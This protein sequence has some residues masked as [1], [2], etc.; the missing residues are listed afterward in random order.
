[1]RV[2]VVEDETLLAEQVKNHLTQQQFSVDLSYDGT[3]GFFK[4]S[5]YPY[6]LAIIDIGLPKMDGLSLIRKARQQ[7]I[8]TP[9]IVLTARG[10][11]Q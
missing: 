1:M 3:D 7:D 8:K 9:V 5:E 10:G 4:I 2:L 11:W 6:D